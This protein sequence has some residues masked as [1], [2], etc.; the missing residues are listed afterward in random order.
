MKLTST[1]FIVYYCS[2]VC[3]YCNTSYHM[4]NIDCIYLSHT[5]S[6][7]LLATIGSFLGENLSHDDL[8]L[9]YKFVVTVA[10]TSANNIPKH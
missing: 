9:A 6:P 1:W 7:L 8:S 10:L 4:S 5:Y 3:N 2:Y